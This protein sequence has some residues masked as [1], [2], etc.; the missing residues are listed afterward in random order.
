MIFQ[1]NHL[2]KK[3]KEKELRK[4]DFV[5][6]KKKVCDVQNSVNRLKMD[7]KRNNNGFIFYLLTVMVSN[8]YQKRDH[9]S[10]KLFGHYFYNDAL[11][12]ITF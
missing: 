2:N 11:L 7:W 3:K 1:Q 5:K 9:F 6:W 4:N 8:V 12:K 10:I